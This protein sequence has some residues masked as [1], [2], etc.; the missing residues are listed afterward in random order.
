MARKKNAKEMH[1]IHNKWK[2]VSAE[3]FIKTLKRI[4]F[5]D[6]WLQYQ[7]MCIFIN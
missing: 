3:R 2:S 7:K 6:I 1:S 4:K 5:I